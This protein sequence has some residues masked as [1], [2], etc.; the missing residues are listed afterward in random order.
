MAA[1]T[2]IAS[3][4][5][6]WRRATLGHI[7]PSIFAFT[8]MYTTIMMSSTS[9]SLSLMP[10]PAAARRRRSRRLRRKRAT[11]DLRLA[12]RLDSFGD[13]GLGEILSGSAWRIDASPVP[14]MVFGDTA[15]GLFGDFGL[16]VAGAA[17]GGG[18]F[19]GV[20]CSGG[21]A[22]VLG[23]GDARADSG[24]D[25]PPSASCVCRVSSRCQSARAAPGSHP[26][27]SL[28]PPCR[29][30]TASLAHRQAY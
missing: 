1:T 8:R 30:L 13:F 21:E 18:A 27:Q 10:T 14:V 23:V 20:D 17:A 2:I 11:L 26:P 4:A 12:L 24:T 7:F 5:K 16:A 28:S 15:V 25:S 19:V 9:L 22:V 3:H 6:L 29:G